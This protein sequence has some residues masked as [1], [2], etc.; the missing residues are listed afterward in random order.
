MIAQIKTNIPSTC[1]Y[2]CCKSGA[3]NQK[4]FI[5]LRSKTCISIVCGLSFL[6]LYWQEALKVSKEKNKVLVKDALEKIEKK[7][8]RIKQLEQE[9]YL[10]HTKLGEKQT[11]LSEMRSELETKNDKIKKLYK[12]AVC[13]RFIAY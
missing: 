4:P 2:G 11:K 5:L 13:L 9:N 6:V 8:A 12:L 1:K 3:F 10:K 7:D